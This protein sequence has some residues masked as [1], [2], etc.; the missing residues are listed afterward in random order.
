LKGI[1]LFGKELKSRNNEKTNSN[2]EIL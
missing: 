1:T 2:C